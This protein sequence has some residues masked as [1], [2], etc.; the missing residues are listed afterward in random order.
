MDI[1]TAKPRTRVRKNIL[2]AEDTDQG[3]L[4][5]KAFLDISPRMRISSASNGTQLLGF[6][7]NSD[8]LPD[9]ILLDVNLQGGQGIMLLKELKSSSAYQEIPVIML[10]H[11]GNTYEVSE[12]Y[13]HNA[14]CVMRKPSDYEELVGIAQT[15]H[16][17]MK[18]FY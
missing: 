15:L 18:K 10:T 16:L 3:V 17:L 14:D 2:I 5:N 11:S 6:L 12:C 4:Y 1:S 13:K 7:R 8:T 9:M